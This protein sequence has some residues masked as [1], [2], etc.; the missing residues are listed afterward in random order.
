[1]FFL[2]LNLLGLLS[3]SLT[4]IDLVE[5][6][7]FEY[8]LHLVWGLLG[9]QSKIIRIYAKSGQ[10]QDSIFDNYGLVLI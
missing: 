7:K 8:C 1:M 9:A 5:D 2:S 6:H 3:V 4:L 10:Y